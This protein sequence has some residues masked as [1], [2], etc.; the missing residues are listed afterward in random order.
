MSKHWGKAAWIRGFWRGLEPYPEPY[1]MRTVFYEHLPEIERFAHANGGD[2]NPRWGD[3]FYNDLCRILSDLV[4]DG[5]LSYRT[6]NIEEGGGRENFIQQYHREIE[7][8]KTIGLC[9][10]EYP[11]EVWVENNATY[12]S[13]LPKTIPL[14]ARLHEKPY[15]INFMSMRGFQATQLVE[16]AALDRRED[17]EIIL[18]LTDFD[19]SGVEMPRD[20]ERRFSRLGMDVA[21]QRIGVVPEQIPAERRT[22]S[23]IS[24]KMRDPRAKR[25][26]ELYGTDQKAYE[27]Q[28]L[29]PPE[30]RT[31]VQRAIMTTVEQSSWTKRDEPDL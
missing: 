31:L 30:L 15:M 18:C 7:P 11:L 2:Q 4:L 8:T 9:Y 12:K 22:T 14:H 17:I 24:Y 6:L 25:F 16:D 5:E 28:A 3:Y 19:P 20:I 10:V 26:I 1:S 29:N 13:L 21:V 23:L 27:C